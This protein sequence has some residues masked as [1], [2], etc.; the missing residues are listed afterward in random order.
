M[1]QSPRPPTPS[2][3]PRVLSELPALAGRFRPQRVPAGAYLFRQGD[4]PAFVYLLR[5]GSVELARR[6]CRRRMTVQV[7]RPGDVFG[8]VPYLA[9]STA[10]FDAR[11]LGDSMVGTMP[12][13]ELLQ[14]LRTRPDVATLW[15]RSV[16][17]RMAGLQRRLMEVL[18][19]ELEVRLA[20]LLLDRA[21]R[22]R[23]SLSQQVLSELLGAHRTSVNRALQELQA[24]GLIEVGYRQIILQDPAGLRR[25]VHGQPLPGL[26][27]PD[28]HD[29]G[30]VST[31]AGRG[32]DRAAR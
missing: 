28:G 27:R 23:V 3:D 13:P 1:T 26:N 9:G 22:N 19:G 8:D 24:A 30:E 31:G 16:A 15:L 29:G 25:V 14:V 32:S 6:R 11:A 5:K 10:P 21:E 4:P 2:M 17:G 20:M 7:L 18:A 12:V